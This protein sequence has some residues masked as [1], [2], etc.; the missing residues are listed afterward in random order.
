MV[1]ATRVR[2]LEGLLK[3]ASDAY[4][5]SDS[6]VMSDAEFDALRDELEQLDPSNAFLSQVGAPVNGS[7]AKVK[8]TI[9]MGSLDK[10][11]TPAEFAT[12]LKSTVSP[13]CGQN[14]RFAVQPK[15]DGS[16]IEILYRNGKFLRAATRGNGIEGEDV[17][18]AMRKAKGVPKTI[19]VMGDV[20]ARGESIISIADWEKHFKTEGHKNPRNSSNGTTARDDG[21]GGEHLNF[22]AFNVIVD[23]VKHSNFD[24]KMAWMASMGFVVAETAVVNSDDL[25]VFIQQ[26]TSRRS[27]FP[28]VID[29]LVVKVN[30]VAD[31]EKLGENNLRPYWARAWKFESEG[32]ESVIKAVT[33]D[34]GTRGTITPVAVIEPLDVAGVTITNITLHNMSEIERKDI[35]IGDEVRVTRAGDVIPYIEKVVRAGSSRKKINVHVCPGCGGSV[36]RDGPFLRCANPQSC[37]GV[38]AKRIK[39]WIT[40]RDIKY[41]GDSN[42]GKILD[43]GIVK[44][45]PELYFLTM[46]S[47][48]AAGVGEGMSIKI[49]DEIKKSMAVNF[50][51]LVG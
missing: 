46:Q 7:G 29:G 30:S 26:W 37:Q 19:P 15:L 43:A 5:N 50:S 24:E 47:L 40:K 21:E 6:S 45:V 51:D 17:T 25:P 3:E 41:L 1:N 35:H 34:I 38:Q 27:K 2:E 32:G 28:F 8:L 39:G 11:Y 44:R 18:P 16:S 9:P 31:Q 22:I 33:W 23:G 4:Y 12:W 36:T 13:V 49:L 10:I 20:F 14:V 48:T 42:L